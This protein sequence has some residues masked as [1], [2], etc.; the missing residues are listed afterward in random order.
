MLDR[1][2]KRGRPASLLIAAAFMVAQQGQYQ[3]SEQLLREAL[4][5]DAASVVA[6]NNLAL[7]LALQK[8]QLDEALELTGKAIQIAGLN[9]SLLDTRAVVYTARGETAKALADLDRAI[10]MTPKPVYY[11]H[12]ARVLS[13]MKD[14]AGASQADAKARQLGLTMEMLSPLERKGVALNHP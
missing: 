6:M 4:Q 12:K 10:A 7:Q 9:P 11:F 1:L 13:A 14:P 2:D 3:K 8:Q 5:K